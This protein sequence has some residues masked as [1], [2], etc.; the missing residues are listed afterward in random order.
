MVNSSILG[1]PME[2][3]IERFSPK[4]KTH[5]TERIELLPTFLRRKLNFGKDARTP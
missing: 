5:K 2:I 4:N 3:T 1:T